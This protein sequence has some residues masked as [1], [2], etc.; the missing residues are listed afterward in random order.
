MNCQDVAK[1]LG[2]L[3]GV[4]VLAWNMYIAVALSERG[5]DIRRLKADVDRLEGKMRYLRRS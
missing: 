1:V 2:A 3:V 4:G 5:H